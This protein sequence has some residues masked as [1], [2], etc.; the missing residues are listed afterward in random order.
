M[1]WETPHIQTAEDAHTGCT[2][3]KCAGER[4]MGGAEQPCAAWEGGEGQGVPSHSGPSGELA[5]TRD[6]PQSP[7]V[8]RPYLGKLCGRP[9][10]LMRIP[11]THLGDPQEFENVIPLETLPA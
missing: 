11:V 10:C 4:A 8:R 7:G 5:G 9:S 6:L 3:G 2:A 1:V